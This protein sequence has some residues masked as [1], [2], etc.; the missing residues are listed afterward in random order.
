MEVRITKLRVAMAA[1]FVLAGV[2]LG[3]LLSPLVGSAVATVG[4]V[5]N[6]SDRSS[7]AYFAKVDPSG[8]L[9]T[10]AIVSGKVAPALPSQ[11]FSVL[12]GIG[13]GSGTNALGPTTATVALTD[14]TFSNYFG[15]QARFLRLDQYSAPAPNTSCSLPR[16]RTLA[17]YGVGSGQSVIASFETPI[18]LGPLASGDAWCLHAIMARPSGDPNNYVDQLTLGGYVLAGTFTPTAA[19]PA[20]LRAVMRNR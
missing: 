10:T 9:K 11:P 5:A 8:A 14:V 17:T 12:R 4:T 15:N 7:S 19:Q 20:K 13:L 6:I 3:S 1:L 16:S 18:V 2:G